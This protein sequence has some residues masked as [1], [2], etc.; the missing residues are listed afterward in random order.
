M[1]R[2][3]RILVGKKRCRRPQALDHT[4]YTGT[5][6]TC[7]TCLQSTD[8][9]TVHRPTSRPPCASSGHHPAPVVAHFI[10]YL[11]NCLVIIVFLVVGE[12]DSSP[13][14]DTCIAACC[15]PLSISTTQFYGLS[16]PTII[17]AGFLTSTAYSCLG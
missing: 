5:E 16:L 17:S 1:E 15:D 2:S 11:S 8:Q 14:P 10:V 6:D 13:R 7:S 3:L 12:R 4:T 9:T